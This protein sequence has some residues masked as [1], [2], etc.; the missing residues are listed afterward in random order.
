MH[1]TNRQNRQYGQEDVSRPEIAP[2]GPGWLPSVVY[3]LSYVAAIVNT[4]AHRAA[5]VYQLSTDMRQY[6]GSTRAC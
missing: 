2:P 1:G 6:T 4:T 5:S 3:D